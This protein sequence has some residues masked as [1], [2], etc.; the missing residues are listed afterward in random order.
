[1]RS[2]PTLILATAA[3]A[4]LVWTGVVL[5][6]EGVAAAGSLYLTTTTVVFLGIGDAALRL[7]GARE[8]SLGWLGLR[9]VVGFSLTAFLVTLLAFVGLGAGSAWVALALACCGW[10]ALCRDLVRRPSSRPVPSHL[11][12]ELLA[13]A[14]VLRLVVEGTGYWTIR[15]ATS[16]FTQYWDDLYHLA[17]VKDGLYRGLPLHGYALETGVGRVAYHPAF[18]TM[19]TVFIGTLRLPV[20]A[21]FL[22][23]VMPMLLLAVVVSVA[24]LAAAWGRSQLAGVLALGMIGLT[25][26]GGRVYGIDTEAG[27]GALRFFVTDPPA[28]MG[29]VGA[30]SC[31]ALVALGDS[32]WTV[33]LAG[34]VAGATTLMATPIALVFGPAFVGTMLYRGWRRPAER[35]R[36]AAAA[37]AAVA[38]AGV[39]YPTTTG[40][41]DGLPAARLGGL[42]RHLLAWPDVSTYSALLPRLVA[43]LRHRGLL[44]S[45]VFLLAFLLF[46]TLGW[47]LVV[48]LLAHWR[49]RRHNVRPFAASQPITGLCVLLAGL[50]VLGGLGLGQAGKGPYAPWNIAIH[51]ISVLWWLGVAAAA[52]A[53]AAALRTV[54]RP[55]WLT[56]KHTWALVALVLVVLV[57]AAL[58]GMARLRSSD[59]GHLPTAVRLLLQGVG[60]RVPARAVIVQG[61]ELESQ[62]WVSAL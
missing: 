5:W 57:V 49:G 10:A 62:N 52:V 33:V 53:L 27:L 36:L 28:A 20:D 21:A 41:S 29:C 13:G 51:T 23:L 34:V 3:V 38:A 19:A 16:Y 47:H 43:P 45:E 58:G 56:T 31:L 26:V 1:M 24:V 9:Y 30:A 15:G 46:G 61:F 54:A 37:L 11:A 2:P 7:V 17:M 32:D 18:D 42:G 14:V 4:L 44:G 55:R 6:R 8:R 60:H 59:G 48:L 22:R 12:G 50:A 39:S 25:V 40:A 35:R